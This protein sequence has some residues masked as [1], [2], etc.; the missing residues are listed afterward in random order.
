MEFNGLTLPSGVDIDPMITLRGHPSGVYA[1]GI[2]ASE[3]LPSGI[4]CKENGICVSGGL[5]GSIAVWNLP[6]VTDPSG[7]SISYE[8][9]LKWISSIGLD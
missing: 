7:S 4:S 1:I 9:N 5:D 2:I 6:L 3:N 8:G